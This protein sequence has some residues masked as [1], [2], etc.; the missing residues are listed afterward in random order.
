MILLC[1]NIIPHNFN[2]LL[3][4]KKYKNIKNQKLI[5]ILILK[6]RWFKYVLIWKLGQ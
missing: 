4:H 2:L 5:Q 6:K 3:K 1:F